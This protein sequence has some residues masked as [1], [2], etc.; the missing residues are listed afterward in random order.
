[1]SSP[2]TVYAIGDVH[3]CPG[4]FCALLRSILA[5]ADASGIPRPKLVCLGDL[6]DRGPDSRA[7]LDMVMSG[8]FRDSFDATV[9]MGNHERMLLDSPADDESMLT[10]LRNGGAETVENYGVEFGRGS[11]RSALERFFDEIP[12]HHLEF[13][14]RMPTI[15]R[16]GGDMFVHAGV[17]PARSLD[18]QLPDTLLW[19]RDHRA[20]DTTTMTARIVHGHTPT[21]FLGIDVRPGRICVDTGSGY[22]GGLLSAVVLVPGKDV[23]SLSVG[24]CRD[25][26]LDIPYNPAAGG[27]FSGA[28]VRPR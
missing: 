7:V 5:D 13:L 12:R 26:G 28:T 3:G 22:D 2:E 27:G 8:W 21:P 17:D 25:G 18:D 14:E 11:A 4:M 24:P 23:R 10:W 1:M 20:M 16:L 6:I 15:L 9:L 19:T